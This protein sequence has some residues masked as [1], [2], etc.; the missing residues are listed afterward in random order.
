M[1]T[2]HVDYYEILGVS[3]SASSE[4]I[5]RAYR[6]RARELHPDANR[7]NPEAEEHFKQLTMA[8]ETLRDPEK[9]RRYDM[10]GPDAAQGAGS[11]PFGDA[12]GMSDIFDAFFGDAFGT[13]RR[14]GRRVQAGPDAST[15]VRVPFE[16]AV[17]GG[18]VEVE[19]ELLVGCERCGGNGAEPGTT[20]VRCRR[21][22]GSGE[23][24][25]VRRSL[26]G[27]IMVASICPTCQGAGEEIDTKCT[28]C[29]G[30]GR[31]AEVKVLT[32][33]V[34]AGV[35]DGT[36]LRLQRRGHAG[37]RGGPP[38]DLYILLEVVPHPSLQRHGNDLVATV[39]IGVAQAMLGARLKVPTLEGDEDLVVPPATQPQRVFVRRGAGVPRLNGRGRGDLRVVVDVVVPDHISPEE[40]KLMRRFAELR[41]E[42]VVE[43]KGFFDKLKSAFS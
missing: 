31:H 20:P 14:G 33:N 29:R 17:F 43:H 32:P 3:S 28:R 18:D 37:P 30:E 38:G 40:E 4:E 12:F 39:K 16:V 24:Q 26:I 13:R 15:V 5:K 27:S 22:Q 35:D 19:V 25:D 2:S 1:A 42:D 41:G 6:R 8:Y 7:E 36:Q 34:P 10:F 23:V 21:C 9:R 11:S